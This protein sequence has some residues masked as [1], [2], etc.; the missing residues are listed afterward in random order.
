MKVEIKSGKIFYLLPRKL[1]KKFIE[2]VINFKKTISK[3]IITISWIRTMILRCFVKRKDVLQF[4]EFEDKT[5]KKHS[6]KL[7]DIN[8]EDEIPVRENGSHQKHPIKENNSKTVN[9][10]LKTP[11]KH[12]DCNKNTTQ[13]KKYRKTPYIHKKQ[14]FS[15]IG[16]MVQRDKAKF[17]KQSKKNKFQ[18]CLVLDKD[19]VFGGTDYQDNQSQCQNPYI[20]II[21]SK[22]SYAR[23]E[24]EENMKINEFLQNQSEFSQ[25]NNTD[26]RSICDMAFKLINSKIISKLIRS[27]DKQ[28]Q[29]T[30][31]K[32]PLERRF[33]AK[34]NP[35]FYKRDHIQFL[36]YEDQQIEKMKRYLRTPYSGIKPSLDS[37]M[38]YEK[39]Q[40]KFNQRRITDSID[41]IKSNQNLNV[42]YEDH[43]RD[44][45]P[46]FK[47][48]DKVSNV[49]S[50]I[51]Y[52][53]TKNKQKKD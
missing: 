28:K 6:K 40:L 47:K 51:S 16:D 19:R 9:F 5:C 11:Q 31:S 3:K 25:I 41:N 35:D 53:F 42:F 36:S 38:N 4:K 26:R 12:P 23:R 29:S 7:S 30:Q 52:G 33:I 50:Y 49:S 43:S 13:F 22:P 2:I 1:L 17:Q 24:Q 45:L 46:K 20:D 10:D 34:T 44:L 37:Y 27:E 32:A 21:D 14:V 18:N 48:I 8:E 39:Q 15:R